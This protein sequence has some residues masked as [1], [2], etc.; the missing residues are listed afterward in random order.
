WQQ[1]Q[2]QFYTRTNGLPV[3]GA[4]QIVVSKTGLV[5]A[6]SGG[7]LVVFEDGKWS[8]TTKPGT[9]QNPPLCLAVARD[10]GIWVGTSADDSGE[11]GCQIFKLG[12]DRRVEEFKPYPW[13]Q[14]TFHTR[15][16]AM[17]EDSEGR[18][19]V[20]FVTAGVYYFEPGGRSWKALV[21]KDAF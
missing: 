1:G 12:D 10:H 13:P 20:G 8:E 4:A 16:Q 3:D 7:K 21:E 2:W 9:F 17:F 14:T 15:P 5:W 19:W 11:K 6:I 18:L